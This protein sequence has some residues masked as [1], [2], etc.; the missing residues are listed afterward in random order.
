MNEGEGGGAY[1][2]GRVAG[3]ETDLRV[4]PG[5]SRG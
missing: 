3:T 4:E 5:L 1:R 2:E